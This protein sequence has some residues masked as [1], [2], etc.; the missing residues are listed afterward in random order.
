MDEL[1]DLILMVCHEEVGANFKL[2]CV[3]KL[4][5]KKMSFHLTST[6]IQSQP[7]ASFAQRAAQYISANN[8]LC[9]QVHGDYSRKV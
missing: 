5:P 1:L 7:N 8:T 6:A 2:P 3:S 9:C 4:Q